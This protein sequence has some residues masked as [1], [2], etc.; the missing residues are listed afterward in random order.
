MTSL[1]SIPVAKNGGRTGGFRYLIKALL[2]LIPGLLLLIFTRLSIEPATASQAIVEQIAPAESIFVSSIPTGTTNVDTPLSEFQTYTG[3]IKIAIGGVS[4]F[5]DILTND[6]DVEVPAC[7]DN[8]QP[9]IHG[10]YL[11]WYMRW[12]G[13]NTTGGASNI[14]PTFDPDLDVNIN[15]AGISAYTIEEEYWGRFDSQSR[16]G[17]AFFRRNAV[18][19]LTSEFETAWVA[20][21]NNI[22][23]SGVTLPTPDEST[24]GIQ[25]SDIYGVGVHVFYECTEFEHVKVSFHTGLDWFYEVEDLPYAGNYSDLVCVTFPA[26]DAG[27]TIDI[28]ALM[29]GQAQ[30]VAPFRG[31]RLYYKTGSGALPTV[32]STDPNGPADS[33]VNG[34]T[35]IR[36]GY[37]SIWT[38]SLGTEWDAVIEPDAIT[39]NAG[40]EWACIQSESA[41]DPANGLAGIS[42]DLLGVAFSVPV[43]PTAV[44]LISFIVRKSAEDEATVEW[45]TGQES[46]NFGFRVMRASTDDFDDAVQIEFVPTSIIGGNGPGATYSYVDSGL[47][48]G[49]YTYWLVDVDTEATETMHGPVTVNV[50]PGT[51]I[52][53]PTVA[54]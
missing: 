22:D 1:F 32:N 13:P 33:I 45:E 3:H 2:C 19:N 49:T 16:P 5:E 4:F 9:I 23:I 27:T 17:N 8:S 35:Q 39:L 28:D 44:E 25:D 46:D 6:F 24:A 40:D 42:G 48:E 50:I 54:Q 51:P 34:G 15:G 26:A 12:R 11:Q 37:T 31:A 53:L 20:G 43:D 30:T 36:D 29:S 38:S 7:A 18:I 14:T 52:F 41:S 10:A 21:T 47:D